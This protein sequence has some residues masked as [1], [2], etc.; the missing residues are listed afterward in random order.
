MM[1]R[2]NRQNNCLRLIDTISRRAKCPT[3]IK[4]LEEIF[5]ENSMKL[6]KMSRDLKSCDQNFKC[7]LVLSI[8]IDHL[9][10]FKLSSVNTSKTRTFL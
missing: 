1:E 10:L 2:N 5:L 3:Q 6:F 9:I 8:R 4:I 7:W